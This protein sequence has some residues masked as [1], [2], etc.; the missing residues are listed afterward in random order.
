MPNMDGITLTRRVRE[1][2][3]NMVIWGL[4]ANAQTEEKERCLA[5]G[6]NL[7]LFKPIDLQQLKAALSGVNMP[8]DGPPLDAFIDMPTLEAQS[9]GDKKLMCQMLELSRIENDK[10]VAAAVQALAREEWELL[11]HHLHRINGTM[12]LLGATV[13]YELA[14]TLENQLAAGLHPPALEKGVLQLEQQIQ[15][16]NAAI[17]AY[18]RSVRH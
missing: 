9:L 15:S 11:Q 1:L 12:Q 17:E 14:E 8:E 5:A 16:L 10:D 6:M 18:S 7:C 3:Q 4:T 13:L 2:N